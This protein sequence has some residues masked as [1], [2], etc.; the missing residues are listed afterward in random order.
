MP[1]SLIEK[2][3]GIIFMPFS[4]RKY[5]AE[6]QNSCAESAGRSKFP[7]DRKKRQNFIIA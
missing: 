7:A 6:V 2:L 1:L 3:S 5:N 4:D